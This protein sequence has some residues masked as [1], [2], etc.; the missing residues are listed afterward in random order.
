MV[1]YRR[2]VT[3]GQIARAAGVGTGTVS[4][5]LNDAQHVSAAT[6]ARVLDVMRR[7]EYRPHAGARTLARNASR[8]LAFV[9]ANRPSMHLYNVT[10]L[11]GVMAACAAHGYSVIYTHF[12]YGPRMK[13][14]ELALPPIVLERGATDG[15][16]LVGINHRNLLDRLADL[17]IPYVLHHSGF[18]GHLDGIRGGDVVAMEDAGGTKAGTTHLISLGHRQ[19]CFIGDAGMPWFRRRLDGYLTAVEWAGLAPRVEWVAAGGDNFD[20]GARSAELLLERPAGCSAIVAGDDLVMLG[21]LDTL[22]RHRISVPAEMSLLGFGDTQ[23]IRY[24]QTPTLSTIRAPRFQIGEQMVTLLLSRLADP[25][26]SPRSV[27]LPTE[28]ILRES[29]GPAPAVLPAAR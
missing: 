8:T 16:L 24:Q 10:T 12:D 9:M 14:A 18:S 21:V 6:R 27:T 23:E 29:C 19:I 28:L 15:L 4:R 1:P 20:A 17:R 7:F 25:Q 2:S 11:N 3:I 5:V 26:L 22:R 13:S